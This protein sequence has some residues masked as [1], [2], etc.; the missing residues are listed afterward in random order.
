M[1]SCVEHKSKA[2]VHH[3][4]GKKPIEKYDRVYFLQDH[5][6]VQAKTSCLFSLSY[7]E[8]SISLNLSAPLNDA[9]DL[10]QFTALPPN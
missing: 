3:F 5:T 4:M 6:Q 1:W 8:S 7:S 9:M 10:T 2:I